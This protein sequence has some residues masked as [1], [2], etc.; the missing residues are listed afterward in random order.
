[1]ATK[2]AWVISD[3]HFGHTNILT[4]KASDGSPL[5]SFESV[6]QMNEVMVKNWNNVVAPTDKVYHLGDVTINPKW[7][8][9]VGRLNGDKVLIK[10]NHDNA[11]LSAY[12]QYFRDVRA[13]HVYNDVIL[14]HIPVHPQNLY[15]F[16]FNIHGHLHDGHVIDPETLN[17][18][19]RYRSVCVEKIGYTPVLL[20]QIVKE[21]HDLN[22]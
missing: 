6:D 20:D 9:I 8:H 12:A 15:R 17:Q 1:M 10:G 18:D 4:F 13:C 21:L 5:R 3:T 22:D 14:S 16:P 2:L 7:L 11:K 19:T